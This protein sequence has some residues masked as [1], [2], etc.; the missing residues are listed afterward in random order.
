VGETTVIFLLR[1]LARA[2]R[3]RIREDQAA[4]FRFRVILFSHAA[5]KEEMNAAAN[6]AG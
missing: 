6:V 2:I 3:Y 1:S 5:G 4:I